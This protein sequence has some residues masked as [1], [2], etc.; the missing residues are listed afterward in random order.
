[1]TRIAVF[2]VEL[3]TNETGLL[4]GSGS[5]PKVLPPGEYFIDM[6][7]SS[8]PAAARRRIRTTLTNIGEN[9]GELRQGSRI[10]LIHLLVKPPRRAESA[11]ASAQ[12]ANKTAAQLQFR[13]HRYPASSAFPILV[14]PNL[15]V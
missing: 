10:A 7:Q 2:T 6:F 9:R 14:G 12:A 11:S 5:R 4:S 13:V 1:V 3:M 15:T 8:L